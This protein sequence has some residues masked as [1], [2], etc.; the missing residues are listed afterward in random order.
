M[1]LFGTTFLVAWFLIMFSYLCL[2]QSSS[3]S[4][5]LEDAIEGDAFFNHFDFYIGLDPTHGFV[6]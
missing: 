6:K 4:Y 5:I 1:T 3:Q 2:A